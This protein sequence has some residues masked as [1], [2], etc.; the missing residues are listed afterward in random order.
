MINTNY[1]GFSELIDQSIFGGTTTSVDLGKKFM[2]KYWSVKRE[3]LTV[4]CLSTEVMDTD[5]SKFRN[6][7]RAF[8]YT[9]PENLLDLVSEVVSEYKLRKDQIES[10]IVKEIKLTQEEKDDYHLD[11]KISVSV[12]AYEKEFF[13]LKC[14]NIN[15]EKGTPDLP[16]KPQFILRALAKLSRERTIEEVFTSPLFLFVLLNFTDLKCPVLRKDVK[17]QYDK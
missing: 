17:L 1:R 9:I 2:R 12:R 6:E 15:L 10:K 7:I 4:R 16:I 3:S 8:L 5:N 14:L 13:Y 11:R